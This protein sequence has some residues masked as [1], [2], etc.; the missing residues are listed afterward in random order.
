L[1]PAATLDHIVVASPDLKSGVQWVRDTLGKTPELGGKH[2]AMGTHNCLL[3]LGEQTYLEV[4]SPDPNAPDPGRPRWFGLDEMKRDASPRLA[5]WVARTTDISACVLSSTEPLGEVAPMSRGNLNWLIT[6]TGDGA[7]PLDGVA[8][9]LIQWQVKTH[10]AEAMRDTGCRLIGL[11][12]HC[13]HIE[14]AR[15]MLRSIGYCGDDVELRQTA[16]DAPA[17]LVATLHTPEGMA[18]LSSK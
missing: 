8:P 1:S 15:T 6:V 10:P 13:P 5:A 16:I 17:H 3:R 2:P 4:I 12:L 14:R 9:V 7:L 11:E 18:E